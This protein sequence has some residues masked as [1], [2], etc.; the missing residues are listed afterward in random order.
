MK[1]PEQRLS[2]QLKVPLRLGG[3]GSLDK[4]C[5]GF[6][7]VGWELGAFRL[8]AWLWVLEVF[9]NFD[10]SS[11]LDLK[12]LNSSL[13]TYR[14]KYIDIPHTPYITTQKKKTACDRRIGSS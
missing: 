7:V 10:L 12:P 1:I 2:P 5:F 3:R 9:E 14:Y 11:Y 4:L 6:W 8:G 13:H